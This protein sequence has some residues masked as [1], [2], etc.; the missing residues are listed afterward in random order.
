MVPN[1]SQLRGEEAEKGRHLPNRIL[2][3]VHQIAKI[4]M[5]FLDRNRKVRR[6]RKQM[7]WRSPEARGITF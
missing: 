6:H 3:L 2:V 1:R 5:T 7:I 4:S